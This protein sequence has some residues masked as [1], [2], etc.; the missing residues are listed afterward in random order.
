MIHNSNK[1]VSHQ[2]DRD[3]ILNDM[4]SLSL[5]SVQSNLLNTFRKGGLFHKLLFTGTMLNA[6]VVPSNEK[7]T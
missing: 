6:R 5:T 1:R 7:F 2:P 4:T 3:V